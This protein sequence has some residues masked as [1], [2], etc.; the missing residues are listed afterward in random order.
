MAIAQQPEGEGRC[1]SSKDC[2]DIFI[3]ALEIV[4]RDRMQNFELK[5]TKSFG[6]PTK[7]LLGSSRSLGLVQLPSSSLLHR[8]SRREQVDRIMTFFI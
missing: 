2:S 8:K 3:P 4:C 6:I 7:V 5:I 1:P